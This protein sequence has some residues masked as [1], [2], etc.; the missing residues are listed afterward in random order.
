[1]YAFALWDAVERELWLARDPYGIKPLYYAVHEG[2]LWYASQARALAECAP[3]DTS[4]DSAGLTG[5]YVW[6]HVPEPFT[7]WNGIKS[8]PAGHLL[9]VRNGHMTEPV[10]YDRIEDAYLSDDPQPLRAG[11]LHEL[12]LESV[13]YHLVADV[14][15]GIFLSAGVDSSLIGALA[16]ELGATIQTVTL[17]FDEFAGTED[18]EAPAAEEL[19]RRL[20]S[21]HTTKRIS[22][23]DFEGMLDDFFQ[24]MDLPSID[25]L[26]TFMVSRVA[27]EQGL[28]VALSGLGGDELF[29]GYPSFD[30][31]PRLLTWIRRVP[32]PEAIGLI[33]RPLLRIV[34]NI[35]PKWA[36][37][38]TQRID[39]PRAYFLRRALHLEEELEM[40]LD[41]DVVTDGLMKIE[42]RSSLSRT[43]ERLQA[44]DRNL[45]AQISALESCWYMRNQLLR[46][47]D[48]S[49][50]A[51][52]LEIRVPFVDAAL[53]KRMG[54]AIASSRP[55]TK[56]DLAASSDLL[57]LK[58]A[59]R[60][61]TGFTT[62]V[63]S[64][65][66]ARKGMRGRG[67]R[68][69]AN[70][71]CRRYRSVSQLGSETGAA[72]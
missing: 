53:L 63:G 6:G 66:G 16:T 68:D 58:L 51:H 30:Q 52:G 1:M 24:A 12:L 8:L 32:S 21:S 20:G 36:G 31:I 69:W 25:G 37:L 5:F 23:N 48:W 28:K 2:T 62:P 7:W 27:A 67:I 40:L 47:T 54:P 60:R 17:A 29:G 71:V 14:P 49:S 26:N 9:R 35:P 44:S 61:K 65:I 41:K 55:P 11:E 38:F 59:D 15:V 56:W 46:D 70:T 43:V 34:P 57:P 19:A 13:R 3:V 42:T 18:D 4:R 72:Q 64:W 22:R 33:A 50:M 10:A 45:R 39:M